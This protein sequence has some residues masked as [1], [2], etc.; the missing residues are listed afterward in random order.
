MTPLWTHQMASNVL[1]GTQFKVDYMYFPGN[2]MY[3]IAPLAVGTFFKCCCFR[4]SQISIIM[5]K[6]LTPVYLFTVILYYILMN[7]DLLAPKVVFFYTWK[8]CE[9]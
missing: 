5:L 7:S 2:L 4:I 3:L 8:V 9:R 6:A 1:N